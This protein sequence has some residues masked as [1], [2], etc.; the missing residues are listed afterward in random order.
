MKFTA[1]GNSTLG[2]T[3]GGG[4]TPNLEYSTDGKNW[5][6]W[7]YS[8]LTINDGESVYLRGNNPNGFSSSDSVCSQFTMSGSLACEG[9]VMSLIGETATE[10]PNFSCFIYMFQNC[11]SLTTAPELPATTLS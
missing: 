8:T 4:N 7:N 2:I 5:M 9:N 11:R 1:T 3:N 10:I 6:E